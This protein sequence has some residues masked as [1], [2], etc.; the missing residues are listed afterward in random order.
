MEK[1]MAGIMEVLKLVAIYQEKQFRKLQQ[2]A[3]DV[4]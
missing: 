3:L 1:I 2:Q 4:F